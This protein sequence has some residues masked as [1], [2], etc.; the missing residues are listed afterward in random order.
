MIK[1]ITM[2]KNKHTDIRLCGKGKSLNK[3]KDEEILQ[4]KFSFQMKIGG[5]G[6]ESHLTRRNEPCDRFEEPRI[7]FRNSKVIKKNA[8]EIHTKLEMHTPEKQPV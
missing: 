1:M 4:I 8:R 7:T 2:V 6:F 3:P 5:L